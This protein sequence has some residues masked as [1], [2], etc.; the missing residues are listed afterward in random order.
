MQVFAGRW[1]QLVPQTENGEWSA[2][3]P[4]KTLGLW[5]ITSGKQGNDGM[6]LQVYSLEDERRNL[7][8]LFNS[9]YKV[10]AELIFVHD[11]PRESR[12]N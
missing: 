8:F 5:L 4:K 10:L 11:T 9:T 6:L 3:L 1:E 2:V 7:F 12:S